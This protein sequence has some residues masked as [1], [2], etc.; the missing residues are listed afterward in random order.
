MPLEKD[1]V[2]VKTVIV[3]PKESRREEFE[4]P[5]H[6]TI[7]VLPGDQHAPYVLG[8]VS[9]FR[10]PLG[11]AFLRPND[12]IRRIGNYVEVG[13]GCLFDRLKIVGDRGDGDTT[14]F[15]LYRE[16]RVLDDEGM[17]R[18]TAITN[19]MRRVGRRTSPDEDKDAA[20]GMAKEFAA[21]RRRR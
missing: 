8:A 16:L 7:N 12:A 14:F 21:A 17:P 2:L 11:E 5:V 18:A 19:F 1:Q 10:A 20:E 4:S 15:C 13:D 3:S 6:D 9:G